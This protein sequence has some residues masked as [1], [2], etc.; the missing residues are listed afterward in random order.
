ML[1]WVSRGR[2]HG[3]CK[4]QQQSAYHDR[5]AAR[6][7]RG[8]RERAHHA[9][10]TND[11]P[12]DKPHQRRFCWLTQKRPGRPP[13]HPTVEGQT[14]RGCCVKEC[15]P[16]LLEIQWP[17]LN[18]Q[19]QRRRGLPADALRRHTAPVCALTPLA[20]PL[21]CPTPCG[22][23]RQR[24]GGSGAG[25]GGCWGGRGRRGGAKRPFEFP[26]MLPLLSSPRNWFFLLAR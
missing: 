5:C 6:Q 11:A 1:G 3:C 9:R 7:H 16:M 21:S 2:W 23:A 14:D 18:Q 20:S 4:T 26:S 12:A 17:R 8:G 24:P 25:G 19:S 15:S 22:A 10:V 13:L